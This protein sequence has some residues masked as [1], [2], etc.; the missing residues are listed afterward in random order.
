[1]NETTD[2]SLFPGSHRLADLARRVPRVAWP[3]IGLAAL[4]TILFVALGYL[5][6][7][8]IAIWVIPTLLPVA[9]II[10]RRDAWDS[11]RVIV[12]GAVSWGSVGALVQVL[13]LGQERFAPESS[14]GTPAGSSLLDLTQLALIISIA[15]PALVAQGLYRRRRTETTWPPALVIAA[16]LVTAAFCVLEA[17]VAIDSYQAWE[18]YRVDSGASPSSSPLSIVAAALG[19]LS[20]LATG[21]LA[22]TTLSAFRANEAPRR[23]WFAVCT[24]SSLLF[25]SELYSH[26]AMQILGAGVIST[27]LMSVLWSATYQVQAVAIL[28]GLVLLLIGFGLGLPKSDEDLLGNVIPDENAPGAVLPDADAPGI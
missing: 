21:A 23:F 7:R 17:K 18:A 28:A 22:W 3:F 13:G 20:L 25:A 19:P 16:L 10:G 14:F 24:G 12:I 5:D 27:D 26:S 4:Q 2:F 6:F 8:N 1:M 9:V 11:A 15:G